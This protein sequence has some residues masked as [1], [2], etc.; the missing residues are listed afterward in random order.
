MDKIAIHVFRRDLRLE[1]NTALNAALSSGLEV[2]PVFVFDPAQSSKNPYFSEYGFTFLIQSLT[3]LDTE[4]KKLG[5][6]LRIYFGKPSQVLSSLQEAHDV[7]LIT[8]NRDY[9][10]FAKKRD[11]E[12]LDQCNK[13]SEICKVYDDALLVI[14][15]ESVKSDGTP[16]TV[17]T[18]FFKKNRSIKVN[19]PVSAIGNF[20]SNS[21]TVGDQRFI[22]EFKVSTSAHYLGGRSEA[23]KLLNRLNTFTNYKDERNFPALNKTTHLSPHLKFGTISAR[24]AYHRIASIL[25]T[26]HTL[27]TELY[28]RDFFS[29][30]AH[31][32]PHIFTG[33]FNRIYDN[34]EWNDDEEMFLRWCEGTTGFPIVDAGMRELNQTGFM[35]N[36]V[37][38]IVASFLTKDLRISW[39]WGERYFAT[40][41]VDYDPSVNNGNWQ[42]AAST[43]CDAQPYFRIFNPWLQ[44]KKFDPE[45]LYIK[46]WIPELQNSTPELIH[47]INLTQGPSM[48]P[49]AIV[50]HSVAAEETKEMFVNTRRGK[51]S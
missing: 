28:W 48:Y 41:L 20:I 2:L 27:I 5:S 46:R 4:L 47:K 30:I 11:Q 6:C 42:W 44:Q 40:K 3:D 26:D 12:I 24:E 50:D 16:Y 45:C 29:S 37:R 34:L 35:H 36:R 22:S 13:K 21:I 17:F 1:D 18:P 25:S 49:S 38:M 39:K 8:F 32:F 15:E 14:P 33:A 10:V 31:F 51:I 19:S 9:T 7:S 43:G 23:L